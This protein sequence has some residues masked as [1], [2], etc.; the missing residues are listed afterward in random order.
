MRHLDELLT[1][2]DFSKDF[3][4]IIKD[5]ADYETYPIVPEEVCLE[6]EQQRVV[7]SNSICITDI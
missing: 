2:L 6:I 7:S 4:G 5:S 1:E 3:I